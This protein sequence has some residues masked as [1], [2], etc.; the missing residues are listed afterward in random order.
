MY[1]QISK[2]LKA[3]QRYTQKRCALYAPR[4]KVLKYKAALD[5]LSYSGELSGC[6]S[7]PKG[8]QSPASV[9]CG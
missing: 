6:G 9:R 1:G 4:P 3:L 7:C 2:D 8:V 5:T